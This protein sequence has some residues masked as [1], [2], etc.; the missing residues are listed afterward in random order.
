M[1]KWSWE[2]HKGDESDGSTE[3]QEDDQSSPSVKESP[4]DDGD[5]D[6]DD[7]DDIH[8][9]S[10]IFKCIG[11]T[12]ER[13]PQEVL[14]EASSRVSKGETVDV[15]LRREPSNPKDSCAIAFDC[16]ISTKW[17]RIGYVVREALDAV[18]DAIQSDSITS[19]KFAWIRF[20]THWSRSAPGWYCG[21]TISKYGD[22]PAEVVRCSSS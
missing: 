5:D 8:T 13:R 7:E 9:H 19:V 12:K 20:I 18:H 1:W 17:E 2:E 16:K 11:A 4:S 22:W 15:R 14:A 21:I 6:D 10:V 3:E